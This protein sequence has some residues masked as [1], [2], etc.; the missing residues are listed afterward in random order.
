MYRK[1]TQSLSPNVGML[2]QRR[3]LLKHSNNIGSMSHNDVLHMY[4]ITGI[5]LTTEAIIA[6]RC[7]ILEISHAHCN[8]YLV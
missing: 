5:C 2:G 7:E 3:R 8:T 4:L 6:V 1:R